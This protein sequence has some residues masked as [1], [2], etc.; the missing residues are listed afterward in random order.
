MRFGRVGSGT[1]LGESMLDDSSI[2]W[3]DS[4][5]EAAT[6]SLRAS[7]EGGT[8]APALWEPGSSPIR[9]AFCS[10]TFKSPERVDHLVT[11]NC[12]QNRYRPRAYGSFKEVILSGWPASQPREQWPRNLA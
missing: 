11:F 12:L 4:G 9:S 10:L 6:G 7:E 1:S 3:T 5:A 8:A 2:D